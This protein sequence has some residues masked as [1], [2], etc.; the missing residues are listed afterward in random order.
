MV[1][2]AGPE[3]LRAVDDGLLEVPAAEE[4]LRALACRPASL[5]N[6]RVDCASDALAHGVDAL[7]HVSALE[8]RFKPLSRGADLLYH[9]FVEVCTVEDR[10]GPAADAVAALLS[11]IEGGLELLSRPAAALA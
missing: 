1:G 3:E 6:R 8:R 9:A 11:P 10:L 7:G 4:P 5:V 2:A